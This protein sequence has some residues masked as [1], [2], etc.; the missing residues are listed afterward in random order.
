[1]RR[2]AAL[3]THQLELADHQHHQAL[4]VQVGARQ[5]HGGD[6]AGPQLLELGLLLLVDLAVVHGGPDGLREGAL[7][8]ADEPRER[9][10]ELTEAPGE[11]EDRQRPLGVVEALARPP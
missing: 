2:S 5:V 11:I 3:V 7:L 4:A 6:R 10:V 1:M 8:V 9:R